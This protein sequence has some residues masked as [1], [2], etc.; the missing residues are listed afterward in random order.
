MVDRLLFFQIWVYGNSLKS[1]LVAVVVPERKALEDWAA[2][3]Q[4]TGDFNT[5]CKSAKARKYF[6]EELN[7]T[8]QKHKVCNSTFACSLLQM[9]S[10]ILTVL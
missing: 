4:E 8:G 3:N 10:Y 5:L 1:F 6:L 7:S 2:H 9:T